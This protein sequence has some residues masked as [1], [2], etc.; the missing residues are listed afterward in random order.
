VSSR[1]R[2]GGW[3]GSSADAG[4]HEG[5]ERAD[6]GR[7]VAD[8]VLGGGL[9][10]LEALGKGI[11]EATDVVGIAAGVVVARPVGVLEAL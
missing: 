8:A 1:R 7:E 2:S 3:G 5:L 11:S 4:G 6:L 10:A 9:L